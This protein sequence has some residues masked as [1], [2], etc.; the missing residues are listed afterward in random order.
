MFQRKRAEQNSAEYY[1]KLWRESEESLKQK[2]E[3][4][5]ALSSA[6]HNFADR[7]EVMES[8]I[9]EGRATLEDVRALK[10]DWQGKL[11]KIKTKKPLPTT[12]IRTID[13]LFQQF[14]RRFAEEDIVFNLVVNGSIIYMTEKI[15]K[16]GDL[17]TLIVN[18][19]KD[20]QI[21][22]NAGEDSFRSITAIIGIKEEHYEFTVFDGGVPFEVDTL[23]R[24]GTGRVT[25]HGDTGG[26]GI[27][28]E[29]TFKTMRE[30]EASLIINE[31]E[32]S[33]AGHSKSVTIR[34]DGK[35]QYIIETYRADD[36]PT[37]DRYTV[38]STTT[39]A[40]MT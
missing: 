16:T 6:T 26:N 17:E 24:L 35:N 21:A 36:F 32:P 23:V 40:E 38:T 4:I 29:T 10:A 14:A 9:A 34:F 22:V 1:E 2:D 19:I 15:I 3:L 18:H 37:S 31:K 27:G 39:Y 20:A 11:T 7:L 30:T 28:F 5:N 8:A 13:N 33:A 12:K 25:T